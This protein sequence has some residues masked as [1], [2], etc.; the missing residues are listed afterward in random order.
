MFAK[1]DYSYIHK[2]LQ[3]QDHLIIFQRRLLLQ[4][5]ATLP[6]K[7]VFAE[8]PGSSAVSTLHSLNKASRQK[9][10]QHAHLVVV[11]SFSM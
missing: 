11:G 1:C 5:I 10:L 3:K 4:D 2:H 9:I 6:K 7:C 8:I